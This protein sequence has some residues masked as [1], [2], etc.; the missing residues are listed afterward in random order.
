LTTAARLDRLLEMMAYWWEGWSFARIGRAY[1]VSRQ[2]VARI[3]TRVG[4]TRRLWRQADHAR[5]DA[6]R[7]ESARVIAEACELLLH[8]LAHRMTVRQR[9]ALAWRAQGLVLSDIA[10]RMRTTAQGVRHLHAAARVRLDRLSR[11]SP[12]GRQP[13]VVTWDSDGVP[14]LDWAMLDLD[15]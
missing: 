12:R 15:A 10:R 4:C 11:T 7:R 14:E 6:P 2:R 13:T 5:A 9:A 3:L 1:G 8:P